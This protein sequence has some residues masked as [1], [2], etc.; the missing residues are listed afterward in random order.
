MNSSSRAP[1]AGS[2]MSDVS[3]GK[4]KTAP[5]QRSRQQGVAEHQNEP[6]KQRDGVDAHRTRLKTTDE[7]ARTGHDAAYAVHRAIDEALVH[8]LPQAVLRQNP[9]RLDEHRV[10]DFI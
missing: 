6:E 8:D 1:S 5:L 9:H 7:R 3:I 4:L 10:V 2:A